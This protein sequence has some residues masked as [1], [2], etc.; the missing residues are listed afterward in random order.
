[1]NDAG[2]FALLISVLAFFI[3]TP[4]I[5]FCFCGNK[6]RRQYRIL[7]NSNCNENSSMA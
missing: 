7:P 3:C 4:T 1:M 6:T 5:A 2:V